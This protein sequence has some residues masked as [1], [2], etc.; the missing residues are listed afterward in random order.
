M[1]PS[2]CA[3]VSIIL[4]VFRFKLL[5]AFAIFASARANRKKDFLSVTSSSSASRDCNRNRRCSMPASIS[6][7]IASLALGLSTS[8]RA[9][10]PDS[11]YMPGPELHSGAVAGF[12][13]PARA[14]RAHVCG[15]RF[16]GWLLPRLPSMP[17]TGQ[18]R[19]ARVQRTFRSVQAAAPDGLSKL[20]LMLA[21]RDQCES[22]STLRLLHRPPHRLPLT[23]AFQI[24]RQ[25]RKPRHIHAIP[26]SQLPTVYR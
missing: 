5:R 24:R 3:I 16:P 8:S 19:Q 14:G 12:G 1:P 15:A 6:A 26:S 22:A 11:P 21:L 20:V 10:S 17:R 4:G 9:S 7:T 13:Y 23:H 18:G 2:Q 25:L